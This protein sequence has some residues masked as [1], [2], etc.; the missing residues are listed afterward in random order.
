MGITTII[1]VG[2]KTKCTMDIA[3]FETIIDDDVGNGKVLIHCDDGVNRSGLF[4]VAYVMYKR[5]IKLLDAIEY[6]HAK[7]GPLLTNK[8]LLQQLL[9]FCHQDRFID[10]G[11]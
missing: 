8:C 7:C 11:H 5:S 6:V 1:N 3:S 4:V 2:E 9:D 10:L